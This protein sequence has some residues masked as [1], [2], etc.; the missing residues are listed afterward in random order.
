ME[1]CRSENG[2]APAGER[3]L[4]IIDLSLDEHKA[5]AALREACI[6]FGFFYIVNHGV[7]DDL[8]A[9]TFKQSER[10]FSQPLEEKQKCASGVLLKGY[11]GMGEETVDPVK[12]TTG[13]TKE[14]FEFSQERSPDKAI[15][16]PERPFHGPNVWPEEAT[17]PGFK[18]TMLNYFEGMFDAG[19]RLLRVLAL[20]L[21]LEPTFFVEHYTDS[22]ATARLLHYDATLSD[23]DA[24]LYACG[25]HTDYGM[26]T[27]LKTD[28]VPGL[29]I[30]WPDGEWVDVYPL[31]RAFIVN[32][33]D[34]LEHWT[35]G[36]FRSTNHRVL[37]T[38][39]RERYSI[40]LFFDS[41]MDVKVECLPTCCSAENPAKYDPVMSGTWLLEKLQ[42]T[43]ITA[44]G[45][46]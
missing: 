36:L 11:Y 21:E 12:Q 18:Q 1:D 20:A 15:A 46:S 41:N 19:M 26:M 38:T 9:D 44:D 33:A 32:I 28:D 31:E 45:G 3:K 17:L 39:G 13:G 5:A 42:A 6:T 37:N 30:Q 4:P 25:E 23:T 29:Q 10:F 24:G 16:T 40:P 27:L 35:N 7:S 8:I 2:A 43:Y 14:S 22:V 34:M